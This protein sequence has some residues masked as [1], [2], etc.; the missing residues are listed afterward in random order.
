[1]KFRQHL[2]L[3]FFSVALDM[4]TH[5]FQTRWCA[6]MNST[7]CTHLQLYMPTGMEGIHS[8]E[9]LSHACKRTWGLGQ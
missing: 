3:V 7:G 8:N 1:M 5:F 6:D 4:Q 9:N 2:H